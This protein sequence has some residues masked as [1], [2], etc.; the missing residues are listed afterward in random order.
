M[1]VEADWILTPQRAAI[2]LPTATAVIAD[3]HLGYDLAR[4][5]AGEA[6]PQSNLDDTLA[7][8]GG[9]IQTWDLRRL[10]VAGDLV[11]NRAGLGLLADWLD[12]LEANGV[13]LTAIVPGNH[14]RSL[15]LDANRLPSFP[16]G[17]RLGDWLVLHGD[18]RLPRGRLLLGHFHPCLRWGGL[19]APCF[20]IRPNRIILPAFSTD[21]A[22]VGVLGKPC[23][24]SYSCAVIAGDQVLDFGQLAE[25][26]KRAPAD[27]N[28][29]R[30]RG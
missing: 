10:V 20:L 14:D 15:A 12:W 8:L 3:L 6:V 13:E 4:L 11:E 24:R 7:A 1:Q 26:M 19:T 27:A 16:C 2:H 22:G 28:R 21:A 18:G 9:L 17:F 25:F 5:A 23:W 29:K 30:R